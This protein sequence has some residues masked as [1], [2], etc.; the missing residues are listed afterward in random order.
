[1]TLIRQILMKRHKQFEFDCLFDYDIEKYNPEAALISAIVCFPWLRKDILDQLADQELSSI[2]TEFY[3]FYI[4]L[5]DDPDSQK[6]QKH[7]RYLIEEHKE[8]LHSGYSANWRIALNDLIWIDN[9]R[10]N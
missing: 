6:L 5:L 9:L 3:K 4:Y 8:Y 10:K 7:I 1:M 2:G